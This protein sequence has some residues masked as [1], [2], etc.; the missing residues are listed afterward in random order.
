MV[1]TD[2]G[3][4]LKVDLAATTM[5]APMAVLDFVAYKLGENLTWPSSKPDPGPDPDPKSNQVRDIIDKLRVASIA[6][7]AL[8]ANAH[9]EEEKQG[10]QKNLLA[11]L[12]DLTP[13]GIWGAGEKA[14]RSSSRY[15]GA[16]PGRS[17]PNL[18]PAPTLSLSPNSHPNASPSPSPS[19]NSS[20]DPSS[21][22][23][24]VQARRPAWRS[25]K[26]RR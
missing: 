3:P 13:S 5:L 22:P 8:K 24:P 2:S 14:L 23:D 7:D 4:M 19:P 16:R 12:K 9:A 25:S 17:N 11:G 1:L 10:T 15:L 26:R 18:A 6:A 20:P 21:D